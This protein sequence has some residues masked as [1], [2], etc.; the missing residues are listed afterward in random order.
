MVGSHRTE[1][2]EGVTTA[3]SDV[4]LERSTEKNNGQGKKAG[5]GCRCIRFGAIYRRVCGLQEGS[6][7]LGRKRVSE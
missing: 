1:V 5:V 6:E 3:R 7:A 4:V 2:W